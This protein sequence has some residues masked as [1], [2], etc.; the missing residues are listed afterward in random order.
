MRNLTQ[1]ATFVEVVNRHSFAD[2]ARH[3][4]LTPA[5]VSKQIHLLEKELGVQLLQR[6]TRSIDLTPAGAIYFEHAKHILEA[7]QQ[8]DAAISKTKEEVSGILKVICGPHFGQQHVLPHIKEF[9]ARYPKLH[10][11]IEFA[12]AIPDLEK[13]KVDLIMGLSS[14][15]PQNCIQRKLIYARNVLC[16]SP[17]YLKTHGIPKKPADLSK[18]DIIAHSMSRPND[19]IEFKNGEKI[20]VNPI[21]YFNDTRA[22][23]FCALEGLGIVELHDYIVE[24][25][26]ANNRLTEILT[27]YVERQ[28]RISLFVAYPQTAHVHLRVRTFI[29]FILEKL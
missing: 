22:M 12:Q 19:V 20:Y 25:D 9:M 4:K 1:I 6:S 23:R 28:K 27:N 26:L 17:E 8:A 16:A 14:G 10:L 15:I 21:L 29:D 5:A 7:C 18:H 11:H 3:L 13:E 24:D 2:T